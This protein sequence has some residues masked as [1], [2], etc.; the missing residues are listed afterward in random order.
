MKRLLCSIVM[1]ASAA[2]FADDKP[3]EISCTI[4]DTGSNLNCIWIGKDS[5]KSMSSDDIAAFVDQSGI[6]SYVTVKSRKGHERSFQPDPSSLPFR[7]LQELK[8]N[9][10][11]S[12]ILRAKLDLF[13]DIEKKVVKLSDDLDAQALQADVVKFDASITG[14]RLKRELRDA[15]KELEGL[16]GNRDKL[17]TTTP[18]FEQLSKTNAIL[19][20]TLSNILVSFQTPGTCMSDMKVFKDKDGS[21]DLRQLDGVGKTFIESCKK[22]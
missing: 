9:G 19:Q 1:L 7:K 14:D 5:K 15:N 12:E 18:Q 21:V 8:K 16:R 4:R 20:T 2:A 6:F 10:S 13:S 11:A 3:T 22:R 17:C